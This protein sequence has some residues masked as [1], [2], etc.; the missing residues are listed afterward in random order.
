MKIALLHT[1]THDESTGSTTLDE[2]ADLLLTLQLTVSRVAYRKSAYNVLNQEKPDIVFNLCSDYGPRIGSPHLALGIL[3][4]LDLTYTG[5]SMLPVSLCNNPLRCQSIIDR[6]QLVISHLPVPDRGKPP[7]PG[8]DL[9]SSLKVPYQE[10]L[11]ILAPGAGRKKQADIDPATPV[12]AI[13]HKVTD[14]YIVNMFLIGV[15][16][17]ALVSSIS[18]PF[19]KELAALA[20]KAYRAFNC[21]GYARIRLSVKDGASSILEVAP[22]SPIPELFDHLRDGISRMDA[23][24]MI[25]NAGIEK[26]NQSRCRRS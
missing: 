21:D 12:N 8:D 11:P 10:R 22:N 15:A 26:R 6:S 7:A 14:E 13:S 18:D 23:V 2:L 16:N 20:M 4:M 17:P 19:P 25:L 5:C 24:R 9:S 3:E 1:E